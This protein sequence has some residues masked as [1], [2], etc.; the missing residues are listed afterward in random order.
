MGV[1]QKWMINFWERLKTPSSKSTKDKRLWDF[2]INV[3]EDQETKG[4]WTRNRIEKWM[5]HGMS[6]EFNQLI[7]SEE[8]FPIN[9]NP[10]HIPNFS[11]LI[12]FVKVLLS[13]RSRMFVV[14]ADPS[15]LI[16]G[17]RQREHFCWVWASRKRDNVWPVSAYVL[18]RGPVALYQVSLLCAQ[19][20]WTCIGE[21][22]VFVYVQ[23]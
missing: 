3:N 12:C 13:V 10:S 1:P 16:K 6:S 17:K 8:S 23:L 5:C 20:Y 15:H 14:K 2:L 22:A 21:S 19:T 9:R 11:H 4:Y 18:D 7:S